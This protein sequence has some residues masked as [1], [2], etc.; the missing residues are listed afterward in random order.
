[1]STKQKKG[2]MK[3]KLVADT[4]PKRPGAVL[5]RSMRAPCKGGIIAPPTMAMT[6]KAA[7]SVVS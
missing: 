2:R 6:N 1:M 5:S 7:P 4:E 3:L